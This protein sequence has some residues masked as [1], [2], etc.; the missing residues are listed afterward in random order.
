VDA[1]PFA[2]FLQQQH[3]YGWLIWSH[4]VSQCNGLHNICHYAGYNQTSGR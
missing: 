3:R 1:R 2:R 4:V